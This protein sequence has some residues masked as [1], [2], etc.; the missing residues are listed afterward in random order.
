MGLFQNSRC[1]RADHGDPENEETRG[2]GGCGAVEQTFTGVKD[3][4]GWRLPMGC[5]PLLV[6]G[7]G[8]WGRGT[9]P[10]PAPSPT[11]MGFPWFVFIIFKFLL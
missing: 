3:G 10:T 11:S 7:V 8:R 5:R 6:P 9:L 2:G 1:R 4:S